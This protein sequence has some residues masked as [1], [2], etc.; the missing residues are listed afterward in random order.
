MRIAV[1]GAGNV[2]GAVGKVWAA[3]GHEVTFALNDPTAEKYRKQLAESPGAKAAKIPD[4]VREAEVVVLAVPWN[5]A[6]SAIASAG[7]LAG[8]VLIDCTNP[9]KPDVSGLE[10]GHTQSGGER[11]AG[12]A[13]GARVF[14]SLNT[15]GA[16][17]MADAA[18]LAGRPMMPVAGDDPDGK[19]VVLKLVADL[20]FEGVDAGPLASARLLEPFGM[21]WIDLALRRGVGRDFAFG[22]IRP[23]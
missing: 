2:G 9:L 20:G 22:M 4:A 10:I 12:W 5:A 6:E 14:K 19:A 15:V 16:N 11:V 23:K 13:K 17:I 7:D 3:K 1:I 8:K 21:F 18:R